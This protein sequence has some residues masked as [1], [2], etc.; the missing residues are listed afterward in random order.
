MRD[1]VEWLKSRLAV[2]QLPFGKRDHDTREK[3][4]LQCGMPAADPVS[5]GWPDPLSSPQADAIRAGKIDDVDIIALFDSME[6]EIRTHRGTFCETA[7]S[8]HDAAP[9]MQMAGW[10]YDNEDTGREYS[11][12]H[13]VESGAVPDATNI[14]AATAEN[15]LTELK[16][17]WKAWNEDRVSIAQMSDENYGFRRALDKISGMIDDESAGLDEAIETATYALRLAKAD[18][19]TEGSDNAD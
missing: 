12:D 17:S 19:T 16:S 15:L 5:R 1:Q 3:W 10:L 13:P 2:L 14:V 4:L 9:E 8:T 18:A 6:R 7:S 11:D